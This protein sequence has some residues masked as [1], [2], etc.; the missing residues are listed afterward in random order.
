M[1]KLFYTL[2][3]TLVINFSWATISIETMIIDDILI[4][5]K[6]YKES[7]EI[8]DAKI[9]KLDTEGSLYKGIIYMGPTRGNV[10]LHIT[11]GR[12]LDVIKYFA[13]AANCKYAFNNEYIII[14]P[15]ALETI[16]INI[17]DQ[18][19][20][21]I[22]ITDSNKN[23]I[24]QVQKLFTEFGIKLELD[25]IKVIDTSIMITSDEEKIKILNSYICLLKYGFK[26]TK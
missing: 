5:E 7:C 26:I 8:I 11:K 15:F 19:A 16:I 4:E 21:N 2:V 22:G 14:Y 12:L 24:K 6:S 17:N 23:D 10:Y 3:Y 9:R 18:L 1:K 25:S 20:K 13:E